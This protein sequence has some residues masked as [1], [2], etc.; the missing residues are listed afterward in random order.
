MTRRST[1]PSTAPSTA[2]VIPVKPPALAKSRLGAFPDAQR[3]DLA[4]AFALDTVAAAQATP[5]VAGVLVV[6][7][8]HVFAAEIARSGCSVIPDGVS[9][10][11]NGTLRQAAA[12]AVRRWPGVLVA[13]LCADVPALRPADLADAL[14]EAAGTDGAAFVR[15]AAGTGTT[16]YTAPY[17]AFAPCFGTDSA[18]AHLEAG[19][20]EISGTLATLRQ[21]VDDVGDLSRALVLGV[22]EHT[23]RA[24][25]RR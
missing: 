11:L 23:S 10:D 1:A 8:D 5:G 22:G 9:G 7:D 24:T 15:D 14:A 25:G 21:D 18:V 13:A 6:T 3:R 19:A 17:E 20:Q 16:L 4:A 12:E 2:V